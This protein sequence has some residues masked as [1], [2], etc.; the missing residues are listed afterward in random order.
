MPRGFQPMAWM[1]LLMYFGTVAE[2]ARISGTD[3]V[4]AHVQVTR[5]QRGSAAPQKDRV[6]LCETAVFRGIDSF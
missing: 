2:E 5:G 3:R 1:V 6:I 4:Q